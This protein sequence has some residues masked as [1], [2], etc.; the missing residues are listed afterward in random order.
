MN[1]LNNIGSALTNFL[2]SRET[3]YTAP[4][5]VDTP[6][7]MS[8]IKYNESRGQT[9]PYRLVRYSGDP[10]LG[11]ANG[12][13]QITDGELRT[14]APKFLGRP[15]SSSEFLQSPALQDQYIHSKVQSLANQG[16]TP[17]QILA[18]QRGGMSASTT[19]EID[20]LVNTHQAY[21]QS[22]MSQY[23]PA[24]TPTVTS[25]INL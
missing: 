18:M 14:Y 3:D 23:G 7:M 25:H 1:E 15:V 11:N 6:K 21:I 24:S 9:N 2:P 10:S 16:R 17:E 4:A 8:A 22:G 5:P 19:P 12:A 20:N 13:Y